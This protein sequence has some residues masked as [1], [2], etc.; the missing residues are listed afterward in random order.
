ME[1][2]EGPTLATPL[3]RDICWTDLT[4]GGIYAVNGEP[5]IPQMRAEGIEG[6]DSSPCRRKLYANFIGAFHHPA[7]PDG[8]APACTHFV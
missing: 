8:P 1:G 3:V 4:G 6:G 2:L 5:Q 7:E